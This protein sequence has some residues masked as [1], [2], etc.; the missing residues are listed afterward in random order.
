[1]GRKRYSRESEDV[2]KAFSLATSCHCPG[3]ALQPDLVLL[4]LDTRNTGIET[5]TVLEK[6]KCLQSF[7]FES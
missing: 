3:K 6:F 1:M 7:R 2:G 4:A 5:A